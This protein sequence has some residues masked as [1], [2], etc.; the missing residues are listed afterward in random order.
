V[1]SGKNDDPALLR[2]GGRAVAEYV[3]SPRVDTRLGP[4]PYL[5]PVR[6]LRGTVVTD[7]LPGDHPHHLGVSMA[8]QDVNGVNLWG[9][10]TYV[11][12]EGYRW[13]DN[14]GQIV[15]AGWSDCREDRAADW[16]RWCAPDGRALLDEV[17][18]MRAAPH[19]ADPSAWVLDVRYTLTNSAGGAVFLGSPATNGRP[20]KAGYGGFFWRAAPGRTRVFDPTTDV[21]EEV[22][23]STAEWVALVGAGPGAAYTL[24]FTGLGEG[25][26]WFVR[27]AEYPGVC[28]ALAFERVREIGP[29]Q[30]LARHHRV[31]V[32]DGE[33]TREEAAVLMAALDPP[34]SV[35]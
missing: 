23:G 9:G 25:D 7:V 32:A 15:H 10:R 35:R 11:R 18:Q 27:A 1:G 6:T 28:V 26:H 21:E 24:V 14:H 34:G 17:R 8:M 19:A 22:N 12:G 13:L 3:V 31:I 29:G 2:V 33:R 16:L 30:R 4:R 5:H 20:D